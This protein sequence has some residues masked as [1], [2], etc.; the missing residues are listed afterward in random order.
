[1]GRDKA[2]LRAGDET[3]LER[4]IGRVAPSVDEVILAGGEAPHPGLAV[5]Q[6]PDIFPGAGPLAGI[7]AGLAAARFETA[8]VVA[9]DYPDV[10]P[11][12]GVRLRQSLA[13]FDAAVPRVFGRA[14]GLCAVYSVRLVP[15]L[16]RLIT[17]GHRRVGSLLESIDVHYLDENDLYPI[18]AD[19]GS[20]R[21]VNTPADYEEWVKTQPRP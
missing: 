16:E 21:N 17:A 1:M 10:D 13:G 12:I 6:V 5:R 11:A 18:D 3:F 15:S 4:I 7:H 14:Q 19:L 2:L 8:W 20:F 9:C